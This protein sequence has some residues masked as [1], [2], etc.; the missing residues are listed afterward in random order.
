MP[1]K[2]YLKENP[3]WTCDNKFQ[4]NMGTKRIYETKISSNRMQDIKKNIRTYEG[5]VVNI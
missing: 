1:I 4:R 5:Y 3:Y 2:K